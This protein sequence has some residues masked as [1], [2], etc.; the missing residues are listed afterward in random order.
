MLLN[1]TPCAVI[2]DGTPVHH[3]NQHLIDIHQSWETRKYMSFQM[4][5]IFM[6]TFPDHYVNGYENREAKS[7]YGKYATFLKE[8]KSLKATCP[9]GLN[10][11]STI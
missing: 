3:H 9:K 8:S 6:N 4:G 5:N 10:H 2:V 11:P 7:P 1:L